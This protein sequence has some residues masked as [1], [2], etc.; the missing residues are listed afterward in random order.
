MLTRH[1][2]LTGDAARLGAIP[3]ASVALVVTSPPY[4]MIEMWDE[5]FS[6]QDEDIRVALAEKDGWRAYRSM[7]A[8][9]D[10]AWREI[11]RVLAPGGIACI[12]I[13]DATRT[14]DGEFALYPSHARILSA[15]VE[16]G[17]TPLPEILW[18]K[19]TN[20][21]NKFMGSGMLPAGA[22]VTLEHEHILIVRK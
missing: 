8:V 12:N 10:R 2:I 4:P 19:Q 5:S 15:L 1:A 11:Y 16:L 9:L 18:R 13:G 3:D 6:R 22:Y 20:A 17:L 7:H 14:I 21:P